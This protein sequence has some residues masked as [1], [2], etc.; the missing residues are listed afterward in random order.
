MSKDE[1][2]SII[3][4]FEQNIDVLSRDLGPM[5]ESFSETKAI[6]GMK[7]RLKIQGKSLA[8]MTCEQENLG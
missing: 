8:E 1:I 7:Y 2:L 4:D 3:S 5:I 6:I